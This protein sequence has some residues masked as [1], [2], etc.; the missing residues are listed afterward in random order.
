MAPWS[1]LRSCCRTSPTPPAWPPSTQNSSRL[2]CLVRRR[3]LCSTPLLNILISTTAECQILQARQTRPL[4]DCYS[5]APFQPQV[6]ASGP[7]VTKSAAEPKASCLLRLWVYQLL[8]LCRTFC[9]ALNSMESAAALH[10]AELNVF[11]RPRNA[12]GPEVLAPDS[13]WELYG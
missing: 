8:L 2:P 10:A 3:S 1:P 9:M 7:I 4:L 6:L 5:Q 12:T 11:F 13:T